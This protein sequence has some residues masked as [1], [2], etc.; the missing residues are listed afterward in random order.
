MYLRAFG[1]STIKFGL[2]QMEW[3][4][5]Q[6][7]SKRST[8]LG[9]DIKSSR[10]K[11][12]PS[13]LFTRNEHYNVPCILIVEIRT[14]NKHLDVNLSVRDG[15]RYVPGVRQALTLAQAGKDNV[16]WYHRAIAWIVSSHI[17]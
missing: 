10:T 8:C 9:L 14:M 16:I 5:V 3:T 2:L 1:S 15:Y 17:L 6:L 13:S 11:F 12:A 7:F 4:A